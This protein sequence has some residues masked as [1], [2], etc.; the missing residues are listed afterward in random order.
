MSV[1]CG[2]GMRAC[3]CAC[4]C[5]CVCVCVCARACVRACV[6]ACLR[7][8][9]RAYV[10]ACVCV[11]VSWYNPENSSA[12]H[13]VQNKTEQNA[14]GQRLTHGEMRKTVKLNQYI[15]FIPSPLPIPPPPLP[16]FVTL[17]PMAG[18]LLLNYSCLSLQ[19]TLSCL[20]WS[21]HCPPYRPVAPHIVLLAGSGFDPLSNFSKDSSILS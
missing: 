5:V 1:L 11:R 4:V 15:P 7:A 20:W 19:I 8:C 10:R 13:I 16:H 14:H 12:L 2:R 3:V 9:V 17:Q 6:R 18:L 21:M